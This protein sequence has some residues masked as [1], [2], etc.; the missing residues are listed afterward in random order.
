MKNT[1]LQKNIY[2]SK[3]VYGDERKF[4]TTSDR[5]KKML[6]IVR[7][8]N[9]PPR[10]V[11]DLGCGTG[12]FSKEVHLM[13]PHSEIYA[14]DIS[15]N[16]LKL[17]KKN[18]TDIHFI[19]ADAEDTLPFNND[20]FD[21]II[22]GEHIEHLTDTDKYLLEIHRV[23]ITNCTLLLSTPNLASWLNR[24]LLLFGKQPFYLEPSLRKTFPVISFL[25]RTMP[26]NL[27]SPPSGH[28]RLFT[29]DILRKLLL[30]YGFDI[31][32]SYGYRFFQR[33]HT[34]IIDWFFSQFPSLAF[35]LIIKAK[36]L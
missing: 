36:K 3:G 19:Y 31:I 20:Y 29:L 6:A 22:S 30:A 13:F 2:E 16:A 26:E 21:L 32:D 14:V 27:E 12:Y 24:I 18:Y 17:A 28:L 7:N 15:K 34:K 23:A 11:L 8:L 10:R 25:G 4:L 35:G 1:L 9:K 33:P 5:L